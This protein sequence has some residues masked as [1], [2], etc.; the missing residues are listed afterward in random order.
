MGHESN[1]EGFS[2]DAAIGRT[3]KIIGTLLIAVGIAW[4]IFGRLAA[5]DAPFLILNWHVAAIPLGLFLLYR[6]K[7]YVARSRPAELIHDTRPLVLY[8]RPFKKDA[9]TVA[10]VLPG[11]ANPAL[12][13]STF[14]TF[15]EQLADAIQ[16]IGPLVALAHPRAALPKPGASR[17]HATDDEWRNLVIELL[18]KARLVVL[19]P[20][21]SEALLWEIG[22]AFEVLNPGQLLLL[23][24]ETNKKEYDAFSH[25]LKKSLV[26]SLPEF[27]GREAF[28][29]FGDDWKPRL[30]LLKAPYLRRSNYK[31][32]RRLINHALEPVFRDLDVDWRPSPIS[33]LTISSQAAAIIVAIVVAALVR[34]GI[35][36]YRKQRAYQKVSS[37]IESGTI[38]KDAGYD[39][40]NPYEFFKKAASSGDVT[41]R[42]TFAAGA[43][44]NVRRNAAGA[45]LR[46]DE[47]AEVEDLDN[48]MR[49]G[50]RYAGHMPIEGSGVQPVRGEL[51][52]YFHEGGAATVEAVCLQSLL[53]CDD[54]RR[55][56]ADA[57]RAL[58]VNLMGSGVGGILP[59]HGQCDIQP[60]ELAERGLRT[61]VATCWYEPG[62][63]LTLVRTNL[64]ETR[65][66]L[67]SAVSDPEVKRLMREA[68]ET[69]K[70]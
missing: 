5:I 47:L 3:L 39:T 25:S 21:E 61:D 1:I 36:E 51:R 70:R 31:P 52:Q 55:L 43:A 11:I 24:H 14:S 12:L 40:L 41:F 58:L 16:P 4:P 69:S 48:A 15:E 13:L 27:A 62:I 53:A 33:A 50:V 45:E 10:R 23:F 66:A 68:L 22:K 18:G 67:E 63:V 46:F 54:V 9:S 2:R 64:A 56:L 20:G 29:A 38:L 60:M 35:S 32:W 28:V 6:G 17:F 42:R 26:V 65:R 49:G 19:R 34:F 30:L 7:Q 37:S 59:S 44:I 8:L 57:E